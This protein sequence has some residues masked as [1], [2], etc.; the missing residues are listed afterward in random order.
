M[1]NH[2]YTIR[3]GNCKQR[4]LANVS[5]YGKVEKIKDSTRDAEAGGLV[6]KN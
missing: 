5:N 1:R 4:R 6:Y 2:I 3:S